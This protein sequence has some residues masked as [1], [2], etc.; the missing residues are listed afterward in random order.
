[1]Q[2]EGWSGVTGGVPE[3]DDGQGENIV[4]VETSGEKIGKLA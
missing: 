4:A 2:S 1:M 3:P